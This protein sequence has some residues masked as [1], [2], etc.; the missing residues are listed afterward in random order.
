MR[1]LP[2]RPASLVRGRLC[3]P[4]WRLQRGHPSP[5]T[6]PSRKTSSRWPLRR[7]HSLPQRTVLSQDSLDSKPV[8]HLT[9][10]AWLS[11]KHQKEGLSSGPLV[12]TLSSYYPG[13]IPGWGTKIPRATQCG[14]NTY[15][16]K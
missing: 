6:I 14:Q 9:P 15:M 11:S 12:K 1:P 5:V 13:S 4:S 10:L 7:L 16:Y 8:S 3:S 2:P